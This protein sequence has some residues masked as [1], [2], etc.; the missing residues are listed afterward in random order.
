M[1][2]TLLVSLAV[3]TVGCGSLDFTGDYSVNTA[4]GPDECGYPD[5]DE[6]ATAENIPI[7][8]RQSDED[9]TA[10]VEVMGLAGV[11]LNATA[12]SNVFNGSVGGNTIEATLIGERA[13]NEGGCSYTTTTDLRAT[14]DGDFLEGTLTLRPLTN[15]HPDCGALAACDGNVVAFNGLRPPTE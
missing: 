4:N 13:A 8:I 7:Q 6:T 12:G 1:R 10:Q 15:M 5:W 11:L 2:R 9:G 3:L 14:L